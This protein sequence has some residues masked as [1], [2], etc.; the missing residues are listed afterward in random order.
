M[1]DDSPTVSISGI[2][3]LFF[4]S[5]APEAL[6][7]W[8]RDNFGIPAVGDGP[9]GCKKAVQRCSRHFRRTLITSAVWTSHSC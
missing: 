2:G 5:E 6:A 1:T 9:P 8:Y 3:G 4:R 7:R